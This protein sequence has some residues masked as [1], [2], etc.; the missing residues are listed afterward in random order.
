MLKNIVGD[1]YMGQIQ[2][3]LC[4]F[5]PLTQFPILDKLKLDFP[6]NHKYGELKVSKIGLK[7]LL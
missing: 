6:M 5:Q 1:W 3:A 7:L 4:K 2:T